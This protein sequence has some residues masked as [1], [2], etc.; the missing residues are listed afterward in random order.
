MDDVSEGCDT[1]RDAPTAGDPSGAPTREPLLPAPDAVLAPLPATA[2]LQDVPCRRLAVLALLVAM[3]LAVVGSLLSGPLPGAAPDGRAQLALVSIDGFRFDYLGRRRADGEYA[4]PVLRRIVERGVVG[5]MQPVFPSKTFPNHHSIA[6][7]LWPAWSG[8]VGNTMFDVATR[9]WFHITENDPA[10]WR[11]EPVW[12]TLSRAGRTTGTVFWPGSS[13]AGRTADAFWDYNA[14]VPYAARV[15]RAI[16]LLGGVAP[17]LD[18][19]AADFVTLYFEG[20]DHAGH[21]HGPDAPQ[22]AVAIA[23]VDAALGALVEALPQL[24]LVVVSDHGMSTVSDERVVDLDSGVE[25]GEA[26][27]VVTSPVLMLMNVS[28]ATAGLYRRLAEVVGAAG[29]ARLFLKEKLPERWHLRESDLV[30]PIVG[31]ADAGYTIKLDNAPRDEARVA[32]AASRAAAGA[33]AGE[34]RPANHPVRGNHGYDNLEPEMQALFV[35]A[36]G[37]FHAR[38]PLSGM[39]ALDVYPLICHVFRAEPAPHNGSL[40]RAQHIVRARL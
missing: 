23:E 12:R 5:S 26:V 30:P 36:G 40:A 17:E 21:Q 35:A 11:G 14:S 15:A 29:H 27:S 1:D 32:G 18:G 6:T 20:V 4:A 10:W 9:K 33:V 7:G 24:N 34:P 13:V 31:V 19:R 28:V 38:T 16:D 2:L 25:V 39:T 37:I 3:L 8:V 22:V